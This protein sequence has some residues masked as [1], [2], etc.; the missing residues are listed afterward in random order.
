LQK[1]GEQKMKMA[2]SF[3]CGVAVCGLIIFGVKPVVPAFAETT[4]A[5]AASEN[6][7][8][9]IISSISGFEK[10]YRDALTEPFIKA[11]SKIYDADIA[12]YYRGLMEKTG[13]TDPGN[14]PD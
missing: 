4:D 3:I 8:Q 11:E 6:A 10:I 12:A 13:L 5:G 14:S 7:T 9:G 2:I 1:L